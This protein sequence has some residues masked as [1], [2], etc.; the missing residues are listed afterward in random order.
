MSQ[1]LSMCKK[2]W[3][4]HV[5]VIF[6][7]AELVFKQNLFNLSFSDIFAFNLHKGRRITHFVK[8]NDVRMC[9]KQLITSLLCNK[10]LMMGTGVSKNIHK[11]FY[12]WSVFK[13]GWNHFYCFA[14]INT[15]TLQTPSFFYIFC[16]LLR[17]QVV[18]F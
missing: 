3:T 11:L 5:H 10:A 13:D 7:V 14:D 2:A 12:E 16:Q 8:T 4:H 6:P 17:F 18:V 9:R 1:L 15:L